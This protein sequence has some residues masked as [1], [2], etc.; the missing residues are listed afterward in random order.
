M[1]PENSY[2]DSYETYNFVP[3]INKSI[4]KSLN[5]KGKAKRNSIQHYQISYHKDMESIK[6]ISNKNNGKID[7]KY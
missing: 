5:I 1:E 6:Q 2:N 4:N 7:N 3:I